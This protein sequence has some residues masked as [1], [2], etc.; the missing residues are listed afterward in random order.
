MQ[1]RKGSTLSF[2]DEIWVFWDAKPKRVWVYD[3]TENH[4]A[5][6]VIDGASFGPQWKGHLIVVCPA[7]LNVS[8]VKVY[9]LGGGQA[10]LPCSEFKFTTQRFE[11]KP[12]RTKRTKR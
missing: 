5:G 6:E 8:S 9:V 10:C 7:D 1:Y 12:R 4:A 11:D 3:P 2:G